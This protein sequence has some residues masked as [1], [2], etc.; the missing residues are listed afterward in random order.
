M[1]SRP[2]LGPQHF[3]VPARL[4][5]KWINAPLRSKMQ[6]DKRLDCVDGFYTNNTLRKNLRNEFKEIGDLEL[7]RKYWLK[8]K[9][10]GGE[11]SELD[12]KIN[13]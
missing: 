13:E 3:M 8:A 12:R 2:P 6:I 5:K 11:N 10:A 1:A 9:D 7:A 4:L